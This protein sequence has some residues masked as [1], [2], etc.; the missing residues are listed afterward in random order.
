MALPRIIITPAL[1]LARAFAT[2]VL[3]LLIALTLG[4]ILV[5]RESERVR[6]MKEQGEG[7]KGKS[8]E[9]KARERS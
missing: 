1:W 5:L 4:A 7:E 9:V 2:K 6:A 3:P 8:A